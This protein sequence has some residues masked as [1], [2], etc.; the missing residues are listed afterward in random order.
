MKAESARLLAAEKGVSY[1]AAK[2]DGTREAC[3]VVVPDAN[4][5]LWVAGCG[6]MASGGE[7]VTVSS[8]T[9]ASAVL[10]V[11]GTNT[12]QWESEGWIKLHNNILTSRR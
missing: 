3:V 2:S 6:S 5:S 9:S 1:F 4:P 11:D 10:V 7:V 8:A 12:N